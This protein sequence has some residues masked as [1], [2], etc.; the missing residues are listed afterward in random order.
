MANPLDEALEDKEKRA[1]ERKAKEVGLW[2]AWNE[3]GRKPEHLTPLL[4]AYNP[5]ISQ[6]VRE[7]RPPAIPESA[8]RAELENHFIKSLETY[9]PERAALSTHINVRLQKAKRYMVQHQ[10]LA[11]V[12]EGQA[13]YIGKIQKAQDQLRDDLGRK[14]THSE[15]ADQVGLAPK[16]VGTILR[17]MRKDIPAS[18][19]GESDPEIK[20]TAREREVLDLLQYNLSQDEKLVFNHLYGREGKAKINS[21]NQLADKLGKSPSQI[22][23]L[24]T[25]ILNKYNQYT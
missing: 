18:V 8:F 22:S 25:S 5:L 14:P 9:N 21:T 2:Q 16:R 17:A 19:F 24:K 7:W 11:Y 12:P 3:S 10:N 23:R 20:S 4:K 1:T 13:A 15:I 6:K